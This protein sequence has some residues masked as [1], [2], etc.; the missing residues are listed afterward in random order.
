MLQA[1]Y[2]RDE[3]KIHSQPEAA[4]RE[5]S[6]EEKA[7]DDGGGPQAPGGEARTTHAPPQ[8]EKDR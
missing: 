1:N 3:E 4:E 2:W 6:A 5:Q 8:W 7:G